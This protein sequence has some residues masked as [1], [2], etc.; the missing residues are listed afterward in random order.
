[1]KMAEKFS[2]MMESDSEPLKDATRYWDEGIQRLVP[3]MI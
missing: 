2:A 3:T 1:M